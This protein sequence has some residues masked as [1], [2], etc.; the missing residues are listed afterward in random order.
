MPEDTPTL[1]VCHGLTG[2]SH[3]SYVR[4]VVAW[5]IK[6]K[7]EGGMGGRAVVVNVSRVVA[8]R[9]SH[10]SSQFRGCAGV[11]VTS[12]QFYSAGTT[13]DLSIALHYVRSILP[14]SSLHGIGFSLGASVLSRYLGESANQSLLSSGIVLGAPWDLPRMSLKLENHWFITPVYSRAM[15]GNLLRVLFSH[16]DRDPAIFDN[17]DSPAAEYMERLKRLRKQRKVTLKEVDQVMVS[18]FGGPQGIGLWP[19]SGAD[20]YYD[21]ASP[22][23]FISSIKRW[24]AHLPTPITAKD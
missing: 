7:E 14:Q 10:H 1:V 22:N 8:R 24:V 16:Y 11:P 17:P 18:R 3:E 15:A 2:G 12:P 9:V 23:R 6:P 21:W 13:L 19:F 20:A 5:L 4:S